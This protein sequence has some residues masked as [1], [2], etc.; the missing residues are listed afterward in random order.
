ML[1]FSTHQF[2]YYPGTGDFGEIGAGAATGS[3]VNVPLPAGCGDTEYVGRLRAVLVPVARAFQPELIL[4]S[5]GFD[6][7]RD[8]PLAAMEVSAAG[9]RR[10]S[11]L[12][13]ALADELCA[14]AS[15]ACSR[16]A[17]RRADS[18]R[19]PAP[20]SARCVPE[21]APARPTPPRPEPGSRAASLL[22][23]VRDVH[24]GQFP[25]IGRL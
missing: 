12:V 17:T 23:R 11:A 20:C 16:A 18:R 15:P 2:P 6:A 9:Y 14:G 3:T 25:G 1:Y 10:M 22:A 8:D 19:A 5:A 13:R 21:R 7:H 24:A 4:V